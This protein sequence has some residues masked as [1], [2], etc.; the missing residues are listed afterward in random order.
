MSQDT[1]ARVREQTPH[2]SNSTQ[3]QTISDALKRHAQSVINN[4]SID[5][6]TRGLIR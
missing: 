2:T 1:S 6:G 3:N 5:A 4:K